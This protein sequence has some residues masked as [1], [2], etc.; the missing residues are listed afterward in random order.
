MFQ[1]NQQYRLHFYYTLSALSLQ[2]LRSTVKVSLKYD[3]TI[4]ELHGITD[5]ISTK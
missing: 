1:G 4:I 2:Y 5:E 3:C